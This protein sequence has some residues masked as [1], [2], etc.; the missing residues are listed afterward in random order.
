MGIDDTEKALLNWAQWSRQGLG[1]RYLSS[2]TIIDRMCRGSTVPEP[3]IG[4]GMAGKVDTAVAALTLADR[5]CGRAVQDY[6]L[7]R[8]NLR[9]LGERLGVS[10]TQANMLLQKGISW[11]AGRLPDQQ[12]L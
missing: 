3:M 10:H 7:E 1:F 8:L 9:Q 6:Y 2:A 12:W 5:A 11:I 4:D